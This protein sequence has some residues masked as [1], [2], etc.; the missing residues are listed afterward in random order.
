MINSNS[1]DELAYSKLTEKSQNIL[2]ILLNYCEKENPENDLSYKWYNIFIIFIK[3]F[4]FLKK[5]KGFKM[6]KTLKL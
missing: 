2:N 1:T 4:N 5:L 3:F 6:I